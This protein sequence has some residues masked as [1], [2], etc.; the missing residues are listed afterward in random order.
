VIKPLLE[1][2]LISKGVTFLDPLNDILPIPRSKALGDKETY[3]R[4][5]LGPLISEKS[6]HLNPAAPGYELALLALQMF[7]VRI[8]DGAD[9]AAMLPHTFEGRVPKSSKD[10]RAAKRVAWLREKARQRERTPTGYGF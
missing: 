9:A 8:D 10:R 4:N 7:P 3:V 5:S 2:E 6:L 1:R